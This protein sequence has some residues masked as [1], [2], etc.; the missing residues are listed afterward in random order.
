[1]TEAASLPSRSQN[2]DQDTADA[3]LAGREP[4]GLSIWG[5]WLEGAFLAAEANSVIALRCAAFFANGPTAA[6]EALRMMAEK[7]PAFAASGLAATISAMGGQRADQVAAAALRP[8]RSEASAN[9][10]RLMDKG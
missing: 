7:P 8:L 3:V 4:I 1:M 5:S 9:V 6:P 10:L 2:P